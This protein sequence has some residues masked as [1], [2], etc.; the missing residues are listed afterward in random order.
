MQDGGRDG[1]NDDHDSNSNSKTHDV[2]NPSQA[3]CFACTIS[4]N[5]SNNQWVEMIIIFISLLRKL[6]SEL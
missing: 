3:L 6:S 4:C 2:P 1:A 5:P